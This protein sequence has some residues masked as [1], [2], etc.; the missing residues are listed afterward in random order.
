MHGSGYASMSLSEE[1]S[2]SFGIVEFPDNFINK[3][4]TWKE[5]AG[6]LTI[7]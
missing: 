3:F 2:N 1:M 4:R 7:G 6:T 5:L